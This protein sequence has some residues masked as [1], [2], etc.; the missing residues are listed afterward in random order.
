MTEPRRRDLFSEPEPLEADRSTGLLPS[1]M[2]WE[3]IATRREIRSVE[4]IAHDQVQPASIDL[5]LGELAY[6]VRA[7]FLPGSRHTVRDKLALLEM[8]RI[9][10]TKGAVLEKDCVYIVEL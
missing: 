7:S 3:A 4:P 10:L 1:Q 8:H 5:R 6:R 2:L 9:D